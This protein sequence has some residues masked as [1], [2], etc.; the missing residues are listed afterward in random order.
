MEEFQRLII[1]IRRRIFKIKTIIISKIFTKFK[2]HLRLLFKQN[3]VIY[4]D[5]IVQIGFKLETRANLAR[6][7]MFYGNKTAYQFTQFEATALCNGVLET[8]LM[9]QVS[10]CC[11][12]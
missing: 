11:F 8:Q 3:G 1:V 5:E 7:G 10:F 9:C 6:L 4:E 2:K 12:L